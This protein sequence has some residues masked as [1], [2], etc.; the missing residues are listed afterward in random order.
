MEMVAFAAKLDTSRICVGNVR[1]QWS[2]QV[3]RAAVSRAAVKATQ[4]AATPTGAAVV[5]SSAIEDLIAL[6]DMRIAVAVVNEYI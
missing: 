4:A 5:D 3:P 2:S 6:V 1:N